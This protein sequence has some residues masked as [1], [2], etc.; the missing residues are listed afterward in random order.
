MDGTPNRRNKAVFFSIVHAALIVA[1]RVLK[2]VLAE[3]LLLQVPNKR[4]L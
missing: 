2:I 4:K 3:L 1:T